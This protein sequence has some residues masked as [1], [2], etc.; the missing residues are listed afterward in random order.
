MIEA[1]P[2]CW[3]ANWPRVIGRRYAPFA[4]SFTKAR[5]GIF[6]EIRLLGGRSPILSSNLTLRQD[7]I[8]YANQAQPKD[9]AVAVY[10]EFKGKSMVF[11][12]DRWKKVEDNL[13][14]VRKTIEAIR[15]IERW[16][17][18]DMMERA[19]TGFVQLPAPDGDSWRE[20][21]QTGHCESL[22]EAERNYRILARDAHPDRG[23]SDDD[24]YRLNRARRQ[25]REELGA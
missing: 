6:D 25:A 15:G 4:T 19:F 17:A 2:L 11:A 5:D 21:L 23:G 16:G 8:P 9:P 12:C 10:F 18:S 22:E 3:P 13:Q 1:Y 14:A 24:M 20:V 7:G